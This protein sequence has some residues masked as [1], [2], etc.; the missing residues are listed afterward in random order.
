MASVLSYARFFDGGNGFRDAFAGREETA[1]SEL[2]SEED[3]ESDDVDSSLNAHLGPIL[4]WI[5]EK[6]Q[7]RIAVKREE[8]PFRM[9]QFLRNFS[10]AN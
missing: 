5:C 6:L 8:Y 1:S 2:S 4:R 3:D 9:F 7:M 10:S